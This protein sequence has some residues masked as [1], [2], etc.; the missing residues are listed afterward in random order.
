[1]FSWLLVW[2]RGDLSLAWWRDRQRWEMSRGIEQSSIDWDA[3]KREAF[4][5]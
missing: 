1:M 5:R 3:M 4:K 2:W